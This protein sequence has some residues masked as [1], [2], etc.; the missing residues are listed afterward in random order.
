MKNLSIAIC[1]VLLLAGCKTGGN[2]TI[3]NKEGNA[4]IV[5]ANTQTH[6]TIYLWPGRVPGGTEAKHDAVQTS[7]KSG[8]VTRLT[9]VSNPAIIVFEPET[10]IKN[11]AGV[12]ICPGGGYEILAIDLEGYEIATWL[13]KLGYTAFVLQY[14]V[15]DKQKEALYDIQRAIRLIRSRIPAW[16]LDADRLGVLGFSAGGSLSARASTRFNLET[17]SKI[18]SIDSISSRP[19]FAVLI[20]P[21]YL[22]QGENRSLTPEILITS[23]TPPMFIFGTTDDSYGNSSLVMTKALRDNNVAVELHFLQEGGHGYGLRPGNIAAETWPLLL[24]DWLTKVVL[25]NK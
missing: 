6:D 5:T 16:D 17:Y 11:G 2:E 19:D 8:N 10:N 12:I 15:P 23:N 24:E 1:L 3:I 25:T 21:A 9:D 4:G 13:N 14:R 22:D 20:Y 7:N 18:D